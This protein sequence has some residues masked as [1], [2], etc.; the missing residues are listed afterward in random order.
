MLVG[1]E[2]GEGVK[3]GRDVVRNCRIVWNGKGRRERERA[4]AS[5]TVPPC[6]TPFQHFNLNLQHCIIIHPARYSSCH[7]CAAGYAIKHG[8]TAVSISNRGDI[9]IQSISNASVS[10]IALLPNVACKSPGCIQGTSGANMECREE[11]STR[12]GERNARA[13]AVCTGSR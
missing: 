7:K 10:A 12:E 1:A 2:R 4:R 5:E 8:T 13:A 6:S 3:E 11:S 9:I